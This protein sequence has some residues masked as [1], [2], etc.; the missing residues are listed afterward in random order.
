[1]GA[2]NFN[3]TSQKFNSYLAGCR[4]HKFDVSEPIL[5]Q[6]EVPKSAYFI[7][8]GVVKAYDIG[9]NGDEKTVA[10]AGRGE[11]IPPA[12]VFYKSPV[13]LY[14]YVAFSNVEVYIIER[15][16]IRQLIDSDKE[17]SRQMFDLYMGLYTGAVQQVN[18]LEQSKGSAKILYI[19]QH[20]VMR[21]GTKLNGNKFIISLRL[22]HQDIASMTGLTRETTS[23]E[24]NRLKKKGIIR[25]Q[26]QHYVIEAKK[27]QTMLGSDEFYNFK[28]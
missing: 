3:I 2:K 5:Y 4:K 18:A 12:W 24:L 10:L 22:T 19:L 21:F 13:S 1:M 28:F 17:L 14:Y 16:K 6:G 26:D 20:L 8:S 11:F 15:D 7:K 27:L 25:Y 9:N 23:V